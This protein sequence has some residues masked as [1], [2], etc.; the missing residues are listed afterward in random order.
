MRILY[1]L[2][3]AAVSL[4][5]AT[6]FA[7]D[8]SKPEVDGGDVWDISNRLMPYKT[9]Y[10]IYQGTSADQ[11]SAEV[12]YSFKYVLAGCS[13]EKKRQ[14][15]HCNKWLRNA[16]F[17]VAYTGE[18]DFYVNTR[19]SGPVINRTS[20]PAVFGRL[21]FY[22]PVFNWV[23]FGFQHRS[24]GQAFEIYDP[25]TPGAVN[26]Q[27]R[28]AYA[29]NDVAFF[30]TI[31]RGSNYFSLAT[32]YGS[33]D[34]TNG[35]STLELSASVKMYTSQDTAV[36]WGPLANTG[37]SILD[38]D[39]ANLSFSYGLID[40]GILKGTRVLLEY[41]IGRDLLKKDSGDVS[42]FVPLTL[43]PDHNDWM[44]PFY[45]RAHFG[46]MDRLS[47]YTRV[48]NSVGAGLAFSY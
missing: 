28:A 11:S 34:Q 1:I 40:S 23:E 13:W 3:V 41:M 8:V 15:Q 16:Q 43:D 27:I 17:Y 2:F 20:N 31:S 48:H 10:A 9:N 6:A 33:E 30:D 5:P 39:V 47:D 38:Y 26:P 25:R 24:D 7:W 45:I 42:L 21:D 19:P 32:G 44:F 14:D 18:F 37:V 4:L 35:R 22:H 29:A 12:Q 46:P 36:N